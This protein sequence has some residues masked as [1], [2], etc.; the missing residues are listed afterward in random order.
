MHLTASLFDSTNLILISHYPTIN[1]YIKES[2]KEDRCLR[3]PVTSP[4]PH[5]KVSSLLAV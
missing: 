1:S 2:V 4:E 3:E 5:S